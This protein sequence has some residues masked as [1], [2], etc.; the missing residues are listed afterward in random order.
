MIAEYHQNNKLKKMMHLC[1]LKAGGG[2]VLTY[3]ISF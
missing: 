1:K 3:F 2:L